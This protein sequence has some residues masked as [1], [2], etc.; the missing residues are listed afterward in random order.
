MASGTIVN[1]TPESGH[2]Q[3]PVV[4][5]GEQSYF[6]WYYWKFPDGTLI[7]WGEF[8]TYFENGRATFSVGYPVAFAVRPSVAATLASGDI[9]LT[10][11]MS[12]VSDQ[13][14]MQL[15]MTMPNAPTFAGAG[16]G[17]WIAIGRWKSWE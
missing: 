9:T 10:A 6:D 13:Y 11:T 3:I 12:Y 5:A 1:N 14:T 4:I 7:Q 16:G 8:L 15:R 2:G 17:T